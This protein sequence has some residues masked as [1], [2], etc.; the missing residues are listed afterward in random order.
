MSRSRCFC[1]ACRPRLS[2]PRA[3]RGGVGEDLQ[4]QHIGP[5]ESAPSTRLRAAIAPPDARAVD[6]HDHRR[7]DAPLRATVA[8][9]RVASRGWDRGVMG[10]VDS[11]VSAVCPARASSTRTV[12]P[13]ISLG[14]RSSDGGEVK[15]VRVAGQQR[16]GGAVRVGE[17]ALLSPSR[18]QARPHIGLARDG[19]HEFHG[20]QRLGVAASCRAAVSGAVKDCGGRAGC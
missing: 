18:A 19:L 2:A 13:T 7:A 3:E 16:Q 5:A 15:S 17:S 10:E 9:S 6:G 11:P 4:A 14:V 20:A 12:W 8:G 1:A